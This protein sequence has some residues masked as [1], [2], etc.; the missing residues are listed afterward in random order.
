MKMKIVSTLFFVA[1]AAFSV[2]LPGAIIVPFLAVVAFG[3]YGVVN[4]AVCRLDLLNDVPNAFRA[5]LAAVGGYLLTLDH[6]FIFPSLGIILYFASIFLNDE[7]QRLA[8]YSVTH[9]RKGGSV[10]LLGIDGSGKSS[11]AGASGEWLRSR[12][13]LVTT[14][15]FHRYLF[16][17]R[18]ASLSSAARG[19]SASGDHATRGRRSGGNPIR[20]L[21]SLADNLILQIWSSIGSR[22][23]GRVVIYDRFIWSTY[24][25]YEALRYPVKPLS[26]IYLLPRPLTAIILDV[27][28]DKS[29]RVIDERG[30]SHIHYP[31]AVLERE[32][33][34]YLAIAARNGY[35]VI[36]ATASFGEVQGR[37]ELHLSRLFPKVGGVGSA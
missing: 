3:V 18:L 22:A 16:V 2:L 15:P 34:S 1:S 29:L 12:G 13:Y 33:A 36:D 35:P 24:I 10:A 6:A 7:Y 11:H 5:L 37:I 19:R 23:E 20:P 27:P 21:L 28:V 4:S 25:K 8:V 17:E 14:L 26:H 32:R 31:R 30:T 9:G